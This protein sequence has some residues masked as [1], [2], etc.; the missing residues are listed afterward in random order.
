MSEGVKTQNKKSVETELKRLEESAAYSA[1]AQF[2]QAKFWRGL[3]LVIG[4]PAAVLAAVSG[5]A[6]LSNVANRV[7]AAYLA[8]GAAAL[9]ALLTTLNTN[10]RTTQAHSAGN[11]YLEVQTAAR[12]LREIDLPVFS[13]EDAR[14]Q[15]QEITA[16]RDEINK[17]ADIPAFYAYWKGKRNIT[18][19]RQTYEVDSQKEVS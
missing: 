8:L 17:T 19:K 2:E 10:R 1:Q 16:R 4:V 9:G 7:M 15:L 18:K 3:N 13:Y 12:Q 5:V 11:A 6:G 14:N